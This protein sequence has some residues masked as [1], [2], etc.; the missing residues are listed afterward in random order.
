MKTVLIP[1]DF[2][3][4]SIKIID[5]FNLN[6]K[7]EDVT[8]IFLHAFKLSDSITD[9]LMLSRR[10]RDYENISEEFYLSL[11]AAKQKYPKLI[12]NLGI[13][14]F[15]GSTVAAFKNLLETLSVDTILF[16]KNYAFQQINK[17]SIDPTILT[18]RCDYPVIDL[19]TSILTTENL[20][21]T[22]MYEVS[23][24]AISA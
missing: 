16:P 19:D 17:Y 6:Y 22:K 7:H 8:F 24:N 15:Y 20:F 4:E 3:V 18:T 23:K 14:Y 10:S 1:T 5:A 2:N 9:L 12:K 13:E 21:E 11:E